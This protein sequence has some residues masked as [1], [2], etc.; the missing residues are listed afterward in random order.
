VTGPSA[1]PQWEAGQADPAGAG[2]QAWAGVAVQACPAARAE[3]ARCGAAAH[4]TTEAEAGSPRPVPEQYL[5]NI[6]ENQAG[7]DA[8]GD[9]AAQLAGREAG[10]RA[11]VGQELAMGEPEAQPE[12]GAWWR[13]VEAARLA[14]AAAPEAGASP[15][16]PEIGDREPELG[17]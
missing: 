1:A 6:V 13:Q 11:Q 9:P 7:I 16:A 4:A 5:K 3:A 17:L 8:V 14:A 10:Q 2:R 12:P 15:D